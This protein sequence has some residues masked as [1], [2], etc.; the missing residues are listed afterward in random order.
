MK[1]GPKNHLQT[2][3]TKKN[4]PKRSEKIQITSLDIKQLI[5]QDHVG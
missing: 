2:T 5:M 4:H 3:T 1:N